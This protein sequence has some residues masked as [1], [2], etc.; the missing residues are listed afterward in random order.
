MR[1]WQMDQNLSFYVNF[2]K[3]ESS[4]LYNALLS[5]EQNKALYW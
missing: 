1:L 2:F 4:F 3:L 5:D